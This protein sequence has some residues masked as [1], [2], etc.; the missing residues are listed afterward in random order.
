MRKLF[1]LV[2]MVAST[3]VMQAQDLH[4]GV[5]LGGAITSFSISNEEDGALE[6]NGKFGF[7]IGGFAEYAI[8]DQFA[9][10]PEL[11]IATAGATFEKSTRDTNYGYVTTSNIK[12]DDK[13]MY[14]NIPILAKYYVNENL[15]F[16]FGPQLGFLMS[17]KYDMEYHSKIVDNNGHVVSQGSD[18]ESN[19]DAKDDVNSTDFGLS[20][21]VGYKLENGMFFDARYYLGLSNIAK[22][23]NTV[24]KNNAIQIGFGYFFN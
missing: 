18:S 4:F 14:I 22:D 16:H 8:N 12:V 19:K 9:F 10:A 21:G 7:H 13:L 15:S 17:A 24:S 23:D 6:P 1:L 3:V 5:R 2:A 20:L 11:N